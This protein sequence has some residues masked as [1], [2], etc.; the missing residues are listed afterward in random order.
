MANLAKEATTM[1][2]VLEPLFRNFD[3]GNFWSPEKEIAYAV[4]S[5]MQVLTEKSGKPVLWCFINQCKSS[6]KY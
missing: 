6:I 5:E 4:L 1:R 2:R 3:A